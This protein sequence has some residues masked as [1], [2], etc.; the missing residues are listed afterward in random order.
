MSLQ[1]AIKQTSSA[2]SLPTTQCLVPHQRGLHP[3]RTLTCPAKLHPA[4]LRTTLRPTAPSTPLASTTSPTAVDCLVVATAATL[5]R[6]AGIALSPTPHRGTTC[7]SYPGPSPGPGRHPAAPHIPPGLDGHPPHAAATAVG[8]AS[9]VV[10][11]PPTCLHWMAASAFLF[12]Q[13]AWVF[14]LD[15][16]AAYLTVSLRGCCSCLRPTGARRPDG[17]PAFIVGC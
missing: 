6:A 15:L 2:G 7:P 10:T 17:L 4:T 1:L 5:S 8:P 11:T 12:S 13:K 3:H 14:T 9:A 16:K